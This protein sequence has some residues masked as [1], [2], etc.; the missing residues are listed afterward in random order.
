[1]DGRVESDWHVFILIIWESARSRIMLD[2]STWKC[3]EAYISWKTIQFHLEQVWENISTCIDRTLLAGEHYQWLTVIITELGY[4]VI[5]QKE[6]YFFG[7]LSRNPSL[8]P[9][10]LCKE[11]ERSDCSLFFHP[12][13]FLWEKTKSGHV[14]YLSINLFCLGLVSYMYKVQKK[15]LPD[16]TSKAT[17]DNCSG[18]FILP[19]LA[20]LHY[21]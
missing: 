21:S 3:R 12:C 19:W 18:K 11:W 20:I 7:I 8:F 1:M 17:W 10:R 6:S 4:P 13:I 15:T 2:A 9:S 16:T 5:L 14:I